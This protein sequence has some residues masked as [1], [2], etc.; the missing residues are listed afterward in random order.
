MASFS[1][2]SVTERPSINAAGQVINSVVITLKTTFGATGSLEIPSDQ[3][4]VLTGS[5]EG[6][7]TLA[8]MLSEKSDQLDAPFSM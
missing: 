2:T 8:Q 5:P 1:V 3:F 7:T 6:K 4:A